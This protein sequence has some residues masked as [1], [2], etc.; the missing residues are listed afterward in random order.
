MNLAKSICPL[1]S[2][3]E[4]R[5][6]F[7]DTRYFECPS[8][9]LRFVLPQFHLSIEEEV[10]RY[11]LHDH[12]ESDPGYENYLRPLYDCLCARFAPP[13]R[14]LD[15]GSGPASVLGKTLVQAGFK[16][17]SYD[18]FFAPQLSSLSSAYD[19]TFAAEVTEHFKMPGDEFKKLRTLTKV[20]GALGIM[21]QLYDGVDFANWYY[22]CD[23]THISFYS[24][25]T[26]HWIQKH[27][28]WNHVEIYGNKTIILF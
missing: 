14:G 16:I 3:R 21:T 2:S 13:A 10:K 20:S 1:C 22:R 27:F 12:P 15:F 8:C 26:F 5:N 19:F 9:K 4:P 6:F 28:G 25:A 11:K 18:P 17:T 24:R 7:A 23:P